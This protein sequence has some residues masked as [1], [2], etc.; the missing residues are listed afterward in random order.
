MWIASASAVE[1]TRGQPEQE[2]PLGLAAIAYRGTVRLDPQGVHWQRKGNKAP[3]SFDIAW[4]DVSRA[5]ARQVRFLASASLFVSAKN[6]LAWNFWTS[7]GRELTRILQTYGPDSEH[8]TSLQ[9][10]S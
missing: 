2:A 5:E 7:G 10:H 6:G 8:R 3:A 1:E 9:P 4:S